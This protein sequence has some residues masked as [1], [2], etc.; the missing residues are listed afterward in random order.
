MAN[1]YLEPSG[2]GIDN[3]FADLVGAGT[4]AIA[5]QSDDGDTSY[6]GNSSGAAARQAYSHAPLPSSVISVQNHYVEH[7]ARS[8]AA[9]PPWPQVNGYVYLAGARTDG[10]IVTL[11]A[12]YV[13]RTETNLARPGGGSWTLADFNA[14]EFGVWHTSGA[15]GNIRLTRCVW[16]LDVTYNTGHQGVIRI[17]APMHGIRQRGRNER[18]RSRRL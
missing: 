1:L 10:S 16:R 4:K 13:M 7:K 2:N 12:T 9:G 15:Y 14:A 5:V 11:S 6:N 3:G 18:T 17:V 8:T